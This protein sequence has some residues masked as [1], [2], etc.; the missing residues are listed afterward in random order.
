MGDGVQMGKIKKVIRNL[1][2]TIVSMIIILVITSFTILISG[3][4]WDL[5]E[6]KH[7]DIAWTYY[8][9]NKV[10]KV[11]NSEGSKYIAGSI[12]DY[13]SPEDRLLYYGYHALNIILISIYVIVSLIGA[14]LLLYRLKLK[15]P[16]NLIIT[17]SEKVANNDLDFK[18][19]YD[20]KD[21][22]GKLCDAFEKM[23]SSL[24]KNNR[25]MWRAME[26]RRKLNAA[27][28]HDLRTP[29]TVLKGYSDFIIKYL[30]DDKISKDKVISTVSLMNE[31]ILRLENY[32]ASMNSIQKLEDIEVIE[33]PVSFDNLCK[34][35]KEAADILSKSKTIIFTSESSSSTIHIDPNLVTQVFENIISNAVHYA[36]EKITVSCEAREGMLTI[37]VSD[38]GE[39][40]TEEALQKATNPF[41]SDREK[42]EQTHLGLGLNICKT[43]IEKYQG[44]L[45]LHNA[46]TGGAVVTSSFR[47]QNN[48][49]SR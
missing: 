42:S 32:V 3:I 40:F 24:E 2:I 49:K 43:L 17:S 28:S 27:F 19:I 1:P 10:P 5:L 14:P 22:M 47:F 31:H 48:T 33:E 36:K 23:R 9:S 16:M 15:K 41:Y 20:S 8:Q 34:T 25:E 21:E 45:I 12:V 4:T 18:L 6:D 13:F 44:Q 26:D 7:M 11:I 37:I 30:P 46:P 29:L 39:G 35:F 38:D